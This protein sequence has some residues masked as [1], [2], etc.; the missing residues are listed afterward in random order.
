MKVLIVDDHPLFREGL[1]FLLAS[2]DP[3]A[4]V[5]QA[6]S[7]EAIEPMAMVPETVDLVLL[8]LMLPGLRSIDAIAEVRRVFVRARIVVLSSDTAPETVSASIEAGAMGYVPKT[9]SPEVLLSA[10][11]L[12]LAN[13][14]YLPAEIMLAARVTD[15]GQGQGH[16][17]SLDQKFS[18]LTNRQRSVLRLLVQGA[19]NKC[20][21]RDL[22]IGEATVKTH[23]AAVFKS[24]GVKNRTEAVYASAKF[25]LR[26]ND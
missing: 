23:V 2:L 11:R 15:H 17:H 12:I 20:I 25:G 14:V 16:G 18:I 3:A 9:A 21:A 1:R 19:P 4:E 5:V 26:L 24:L 13:G 10:L 22:N 6:G 8:D 7:Y